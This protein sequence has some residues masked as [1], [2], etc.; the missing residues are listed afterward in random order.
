MSDSAYLG[1]R[2]GDL[3]DKPYAKFWQP[4]MS[5]MPSHVTEAL[6]R[7]EEAQELAFGLGDAGELLNPG[8]LPLENGY[9]R[10]KNS[11]IFVAVLTEMPGATGAMFEWWMGWHYM[12]AQRYKLWHPRAH[13]DNGTKEMRGDDPTLSDREKYMTTHYVTEYIGNHLDSITI[14]FLDPRRLFGEKADLSSGGT[15]A[16]VCGR[17]DLQRAPITVGWIIHQIRELED[18]AEMR[19]RF[20]LGRPEIS[21]SRGGDPRNW[22]LRSPWFQRMAMPRNLGQD[23]L[24]HCAM[25]MNHL[26]SFLPELYGLYHPDAEGREL[27]RG[28]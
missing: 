14:T 20:W 23:M 24:V 2:P 28:V 6:L 7:G 11:Q 4:E 10:L 17:V 9:T 8:Y 19:S 1:M 3:D 26:A 16:L 21:G 27:N 22:L 5:P 13:V 12:E 18:G 15:T 25:E